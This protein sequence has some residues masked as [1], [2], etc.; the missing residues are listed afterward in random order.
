MAISVQCVCGRKLKAPDQFAGTRAECPSCGL[1]LLIPVVE[2]T[3]LPDPVPAGESEPS[4]YATRSPEA[5]YEKIQLGADNIYEFLDPP[6]STVPPPPP[7]AARTLSLRMMFEALLDPRSIQWMLTLGGGL[8]VLGVVIWLVSLGIFKD[9]LVMAIAMGLGTGA[10]LAG[11]WWLTL[12]SR[13]HMA[14]QALTFLGCVLA[15]LNL[16]FYD[17]QNL[18]TLDDHLWVGG[19]ICC[20]IYIATVTVLR[21]PLFMYAVEAGVTL[22]ALLLLA[23]LQWIHDTS[24]LCTFLMAIGLFSIHSERAFAPGEAEHFNRRRFG[25]PLFWSGH[26]QLA[27]ALV[28]LLATQACA[29]IFDPLRSPLP[30]AWA[31]NFLSHSPLLAGALWLAGAYA[32]LYSDLVVRRVGVYTYAAAFCLLIGEVTIVGDH[33]QTEGVIAILA[34]TALVANM[35]RSSLQQSSDKLHRTITPLALGMSALPVLMGIFLHLRATSLLAGNVWG[36]YAS[37]WPFIAVMVLVA[38]C[39]RVSA[40]LFRHENSKASAS[41]F[42]LSAGSLIVAAAGLLR[43]FELVSWSQQAPLLMMIPIAYL[44]ASRLWMGQSPE[45]P[46]VWVAHTATAVILTHGLLATFDTLDMVV[47]PIQGHRDNLLLGIVFAEAAVFYMLAGLF[48]KRSSNVYFAAAAACASLWQLIGYWGAIDQAYYTMLYA[49]VGASLLAISRVIGIEQ[50][51]VYG[52]NGEQSKRIR[53]RG[54]P[55]LQSG[56]AILIV[57][58]LAATLQGLMQLATQRATS[59]TLTA[60]LLTTLASFAAI[61]LAPAGSWRRL[62]WSSS[63]M[64]SALCF[65]TFNVLINLSLWQ[66]LEIFCVVLGIVLISASY[67]RRFLEIHKVSDDS[68]TMGLW[69]GSLLVTIPLISAL[70]FYRFNRGVIHWP[71]EVAIVV[72]TILML[73]T[74]YSWKVKSTT[75]SGGGTLFLYLLI[76]IGQLAYRPQVATGVYLAVGGGLVFLTGVCLS[77]YREALLQLPDRI[78]KRE[79]V[80]QIIGWR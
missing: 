1:P 37:G 49:V 42:F 61:A 6:Q 5:S 32:Y 9:P 25:M 24:F 16:W 28:I 27:A 23:D 44:M 65:L 21:D 14:G 53:G 20:L 76:T 62:Y 67:I 45:R 64:M 18:V 74:G 57:A 52:A 29:W 72:L 51:N 59:L 34:I 31:G 70:C 79:G 40:F 60:L 66:K 15:P 56:N 26:V 39:N 35:L 10:V 36:P 11:G 75:L 12:R 77:M 73:V 2:V 8:L 41:Y 30:A 13:F 33:L 47:Q 58:L 50:V 55:L 19:V 43:Q 78:A 54:L 4:T 80:F 69:F 63:I 7:P 38:V 46:L 17:S 22:T 71:E 48:R 68:V 3:P